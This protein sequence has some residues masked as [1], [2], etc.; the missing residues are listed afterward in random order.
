LKNEFDYETEDEERKSSSKT[1]LHEVQQAISFFIKKNP[2]KLV[3]N[4]SL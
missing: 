1:L 4:I 2:F 3:D